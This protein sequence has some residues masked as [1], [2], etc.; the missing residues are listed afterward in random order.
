MAG[1]R[2]PHTYTDDS[3]KSTDLSYTNGHTGS[4]GAAT[5]PSGPKLGALT[6]RPVV[7]PDTNLCPDSVTFIPAIKEGEE[8]HLQS[9]LTV[10]LGNGTGLVSREDAM[11]N[12]TGYTLGVSSRIRQVGVNSDPGLD[13]HGKSS[14]TFHT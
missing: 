12:V 5:K 2:H 6:T 3:T 8:M 13:Y 4:G 10:M 9:H 14:Y 11:D 1:Q 7:R